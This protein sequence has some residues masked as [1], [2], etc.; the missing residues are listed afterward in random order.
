[1]T[2][3]LQRFRQHDTR[4]FFAGLL[5]LAYVF[6]AFIPVGYMPDMDALRKGVFT[7][8]ICTSHGAKTILADDQGQPAKKD[9]SKR[10][11]GCLFGWSP[12]VAIETPALLFTP[13]VFLF[14]ETVQREAD[15]NIVREFFSGLQARAPPAV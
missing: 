5:L 14:V 13:A 2:S 15:L 4:L 11:P 1:M 10:D 9:N 6:R 8:A 3:L 12:K 7:L